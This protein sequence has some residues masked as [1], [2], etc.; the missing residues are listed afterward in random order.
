MC[1]LIALIPKNQDWLTSDNVNMFKELLWVGALR[2]W[3]GTGI[4]S[5]KWNKVETFKKPG[6]PQ[7]LITQINEDKVSLFGKMLVG[8]NRA[9]TRGKNILEHTHP[10]REKHITLVHNGTLWDH[11]DLG[12][13][14]VDSHAICEFISNT[15]NPQHIIDNLK[16]DYALIWYD[17]KQNKLFALRNEKRPLFLIKTDSIYLLVS[18]K[19]MGIW[20]LSRF[21]HT[22]LSVQEIKPFTLYSFKEK[23]TYKKL[24]LK[25]VN[26]PPIQ[27]SFF[28]TKQN[29]L[30]IGDKFKATVWYCKFNDIKKNY[31]C[32]GTLEND[33]YTDV[34]FVSNVNFEHK[35]IELIY[36]KT[37]TINN[38]FDIIHGH[39]PSLIKK[40]KTVTV[41]IQKQQT[42]NQPLVTKNGI[43]LTNSIIQKVWDRTC[44]K[45][46]ANFIYSPAIK[47]EQVPKNSKTFIYRYTCP[48]CAA[49][50][51]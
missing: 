33:N 50:E 20:L 10:F 30:K 11:S 32:F 46:G 4:I 5:V 37:E 35:S 7:N 25:K 13:K 42:K 22:D 28:T 2:G 49:N 15:T 36:F 23:E 29:T 9:T 31:T 45:C 51:N 26:F 8:H 48:K 43:E 40:N 34:E 41:K 12:D 3:N 39:S 21:N 18:E 17:E 24:Q 6:P 1:G 27:S 19:E 44:Y 14:E 16:G 47:I 38:N